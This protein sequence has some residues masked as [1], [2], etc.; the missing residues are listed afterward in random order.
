MLNRIGVQSRIIFGIAGFLAFICVVFGLYRTAQQEYVK[1]LVLLI[2]FFSSIGVIA[3]IYFGRQQTGRILFI[4]LMY[5]LLLT[6]NLK[7]HI[8]QILWQYPGIVAMTFALRGYKE[9][10]TI[11]LSL[12]VLNT[13]ALSDYAEVN[14]LVTYAGSQLSLIFLCAVVVEL[15]MSKHTIGANGRRNRQFNWTQK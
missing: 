1:A 6:I 9:V 3:C 11:C 13:I 15:L 10:F 2:T 12:V 4:C 5:V 14:L 7:F 8:E